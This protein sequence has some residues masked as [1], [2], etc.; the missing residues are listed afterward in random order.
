M[1]A[2]TD[3]QPIHKQEDGESRTNSPSFLAPRD[4]LVWPLL[5]FLVLSTQTPYH[6]LFPHVDLTA[7]FETDLLDGLGLWVLF[8]K[9]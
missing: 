2:Q 3:R 6:T 5:S 8:G 1:Q 7:H 9:F 4:Y